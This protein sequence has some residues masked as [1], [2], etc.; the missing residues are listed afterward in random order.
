M[1]SDKS[2]VTDN[3]DA[4]EARLANTLQPVAPS[5]GFV[6]TLRGR[7]SMPT[8]EVLVERLKFPTVFIAFASV[9][10]ASLVILTIA[11]AFFYFAHRERS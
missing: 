7:M 10:S 6:S 4:M 3:F 11:R 1:A 8:R 2:P 5:S 9:I